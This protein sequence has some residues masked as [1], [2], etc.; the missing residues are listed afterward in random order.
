MYTSTHINASSQNSMICVSI[1]YIT[2]QWLFN[3]TSIQK[4]SCCDL[5]QGK[6]NEL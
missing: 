3:D 1:T 2:S 6:K 5:A 4:A